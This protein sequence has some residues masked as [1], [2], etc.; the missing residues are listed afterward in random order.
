MVCIK[1][2][3]QKNV[4]LASIVT[5]IEIVYFRLLLNNAGWRIK[6]FALDKT[7]TH[8]Y[9]SPIH[10]IFIPN[11]STLLYIIF[12]FLSCHEIIA[13]FTFW[14]LQIWTRSVI[15]CPTPSITLLLFLEDNNTVQLWNNIHIWVGD[16][17]PF[18]NKKWIKSCT[19]TDS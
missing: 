1:Y 19:I 2:K 18:T 9:H 3:L 11:L 16:D 12:L 6:S 5:S 4:D 17:I 8:C 14:W 13:R 7:F 15:V 10:W